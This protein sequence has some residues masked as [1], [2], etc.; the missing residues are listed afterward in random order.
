MADENPP[1]YKVYRS[2]PRL[3]SSARA[4]GRRPRRA[5]RAR[6]AGPGAAGLRGPQDGPPRPPPADPAAP[7]AAA[8]PAPRAAGS[9][10]ARRSSGSRSRCS[11]GSPSP[12]SCSWSP[13]RS[14][15]ATWPTRSAT[16]STP[17][18]SRSPG[19]NTILVLGS[20]ARTEGL[21]EPGSGGP[22]RCGLDH[23]AAHRR[24][25]ERVALDP[26]RHGRRHPRPRD[27]QDQRRVRVRRRR[28]RH[29]D[30]QGVARGRGQPRRRGQLRELPAADRRARRRDLQGPRRA[31]EDQRR[32]PQRRLH[33]APAQGR[34]GDRRQAGARARPHAQEP[35]RPERERPHA[36]PPPAAARAGDEGQGH[37]VRDVRP[38]AVGVVGG[39]EG[40]ALRHG[41][42]DAARRRDGVDDRRR[43]PAAGARALGRRRRSPTA[44]PA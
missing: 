33:A 29:A 34:D 18:R 19:A 38:A 31:L 12:P 26:A 23:A 24:R 28:P 2:R 15:A 27:E 7:R 4:G 17:A 8:S 37:V 30:G 22:S 40:R 3:L 39:A 35:P 25:R 21:A 14:S 44:A 41:R 9:R 1:E 36:R 10:R 16:S 43:Q 20:D 5:A 42:P 13:P 32:P 11:P 6:R